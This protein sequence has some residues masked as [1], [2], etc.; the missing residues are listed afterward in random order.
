MSYR[1][2]WVRSAVRKFNSLPAQTAVRL[3]QAV[4]RLADDPR[5]YGCKK[6]TGHKALWRNRIG[7]YRIIYFIGNGI[8]LERIEK[9]SSGKDAYR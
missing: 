1:I 2:E 8:K 9:V 6:H 7:N 3:G 4:G 5:P